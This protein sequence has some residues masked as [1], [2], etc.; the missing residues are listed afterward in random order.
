MLFSNTLNWVNTSKQSITGITRKK[1]TPILR[2]TYGS[3]PLSLA[4]CA[5][6]VGHGPGLAELGERCPA[7]EGH[8]EEGLIPERFLQIVVNLDFRH[9]SVQ[10]IGQ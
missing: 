5:L 4:H 10:S 3:F 8:Q 9:D 1:S 7:V 2:K 6:Q